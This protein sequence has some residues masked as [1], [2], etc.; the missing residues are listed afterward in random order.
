MPPTICGFE[1]IGVFPQSV[2]N[3]DPAFSKGTVSSF[4]EGVV[5]EIG[6]ETVDSLGGQQCKPVAP[7]LASCPDMSYVTLHSF[8]GLQMPNFFP[9]VRHLVP[10]AVHVCRSITNKKNKF[11]MIM[12]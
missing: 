2:G 9:F 7:H 4:D 11:I 10:R 8:R 6:R 12:R 5:D 1:Y 3:F